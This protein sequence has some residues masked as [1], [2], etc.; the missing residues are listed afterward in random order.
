MMKYERPE[1][2]M[3]EFDAHDIIVASGFGP[4]GQSAAEAAALIHSDVIAAINN[5]GGN[6]YAEVDT[7]ASVY[8]PVTGEWSI[9]VRIFNHGG[10]QKDVVVVLV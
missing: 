1:A 10:K 7:S 8:N 9:T 2:E 3:I 6:A 4:N 5:V